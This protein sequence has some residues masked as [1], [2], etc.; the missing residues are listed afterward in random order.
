MSTITKVFED[1]YGLLEYHPQSKIVSHV[2][3]PGIAGEHLRN[4]LN[5]GVDLLKQHGAVKWL[6]D[7]R[8]FVDVLDEDAQWVNEVWIN[9]AM[10][11]GWKYWALVVPKDE[12]GRL[13]MVGFVQDFANLGVVTRVFTSV[14]PAHEW[15]LSV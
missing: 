5:Q 15:L 11:A 4:L 2:F 12:A 6:A 14:E 3:K 13:N 9:N 1:E 10:K 7:N 8:G